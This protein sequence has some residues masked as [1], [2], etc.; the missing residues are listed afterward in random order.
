MLITEGYKVFVLC[1]IGYIYS[2]I[3]TYKLNSSIGLIIQE[4][5]TPTGSMVFQLASS[6]PSTCERHFSVY[7][8][9]YFTL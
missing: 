5:L 7:M 9:N 1:D 4:D 2:W 8:N 3:F 6:L